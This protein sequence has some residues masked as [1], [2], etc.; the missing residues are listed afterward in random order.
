MKNV[1]S[2]VGL[3][4]QEEKVLLALI[5]PHITIAVIPKMSRWS[6]LLTALMNIKMYSL[7]SSLDV[8]CSS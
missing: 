2:K 3:D 7:K 8:Y 1:L 5:T 4:V 6:S